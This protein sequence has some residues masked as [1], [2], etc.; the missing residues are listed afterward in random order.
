MVASEPEPA[1]DDEKP[2]SEADSK[3]SDEPAP[4]APPRML[5]LPTLKIEGAEV[6]RGV[7]V[8]IEC[9]RGKWTLVVQKGSNI[10]NFVVSNKDKLEFYSQD[11]NFEGTMNCGPVAH[12]AFIY[13][14]PIA[15]QTKL[16]GDAV[17]V[18]F[19]K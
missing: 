11:P 19:T 2:E 5:G 8:R 14:K 9:A 15:G 1:P 6:M 10:F 16:A 18:E 4:K 13:F 7:L 3:S 12:V 17:A